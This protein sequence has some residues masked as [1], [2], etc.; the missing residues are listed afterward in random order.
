M[1]RIL[2]AIIPA[3]RLRQEDY[4]EP[5]TSQEYTVSPRLSLRYMARFHLKNKNKQK[6]K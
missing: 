2:I 6:K 5:E 3:L 4:H 1:G